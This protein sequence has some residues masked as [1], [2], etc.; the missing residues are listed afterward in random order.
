[1]IDQKEAI[2]QLWIKWKASRDSDTANRLVEY[3]LYLIDYHVQR[4]SAHLPQNVLRDD[5]RSL[6]FV[7]LF[8]A[9]QKFEPERDLKF[10]TYAS[11]RIRGTI[12]DGLRKEDWLSRLTRERAKKIDQATSML[13][14]QLQRQ[15]TASEIA[16]HLNITTQE[17]E[18]SY[19]DVLFANLL[20]MEEKTSDDSDDYKEGIG[21]S[22][23][24]NQQLSPEDLMVKQEN[25]QE[26]ANSIHNLNKNE[27]LVISLFY[28]EE[29]S[30]TEIGQVLSLT[31]SRI[32]QIHKQAIFKLRHA[33][34]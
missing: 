14:Q 16:K 26:L 1:M 31:T 29:L 2:D 22:I 5:I 9:L 28:H 23:I 34:S 20:S 18:T 17:V 11:F 24:D 15:P 32:S 7:G 13:T 27:Q 21:H 10:D 19:K 8:D 25:Y 30:F 4:I 6:G 12:I 3:Y 33:L